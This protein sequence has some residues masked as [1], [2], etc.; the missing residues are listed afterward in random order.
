MGLSSADTITRKKRR[1]LV[2][3]EQWAIETSEYDLTTRE[4]PPSFVRFGSTNILYL[5]YG[6][7]PVLKRPAVPTSGCV[8]FGNGIS[9][10]LSSVVGFEGIEK[11][12]YRHGHQTHDLLCHPWQHR[13]LRL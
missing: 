2:L 8:F 13:S 12:N 6:F 9:K 7:V 1:A 4:Q 11:K 5:T 10:A 3:W